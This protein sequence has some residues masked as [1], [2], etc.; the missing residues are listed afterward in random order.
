MTRS[1]LAVR[2]AAA[3]AE[4]VSAARQVACLREELAKEDEHRYYLDEL[5]NRVTG[6]LKAAVIRDRGV[7]R[8]ST[9]APVLHFPVATVDRVG[10]LTEEEVLAA[11]NQLLAMYRGAER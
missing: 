9:Y 10:S 8:R 4:L 5:R 6:R 1:E 11:A 3:E 7:V 2:I